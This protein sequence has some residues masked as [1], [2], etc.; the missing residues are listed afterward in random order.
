MKYVFAAFGGSGSTE[1]IRRLSSRYV[2]GNK[3]DAVFF[4]QLG[5]VR[6]DQGT[7]AERSRGF[8]PP[9]GATL[10][11]A[12]TAYCRWLAARPDHTAV[13]NTAAGEGVFSAAGIPDVVFLLRHPVHAYVSWAKPE[14]HG[15]LLEQFGGVNSEPGVTWY[16]RRWKLAAREYLRLRAARIPC[17]LVRYE[18][19]ERDARSLPELRAI[20]AGFDGG[21]RNP[22]VLR[23]E[24]EELMFESVRIVYSELYP[25]WAV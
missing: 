14:R 8:S 7:F 11:Q 10:Q 2:V 4:T 25:S 5:A 9:P 16:A 1:L 22:G 12:V 20:F 6:I 21:R 13:F 3:P 19:A 18:H 17:A 23:P 24:L 15:S